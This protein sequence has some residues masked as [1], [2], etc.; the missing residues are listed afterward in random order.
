MHELGVIYEI[1]KTVAEIKAEE[2]LERVTAITLQIG[3]RSG[4]VAP[5]LQACWKAVAPATDFPEMEMRVEQLPAIAM[6]QH[7]A[8]F[9]AHLSCA[10]R[11]PHCGSRDYEI[12]SGYE[13]NIKSIEAC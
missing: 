4:V 11:C 8:S 1:V 9:Y 13:F 2:K 5:Y 7:C 6:C 10:R 3:E 12:I